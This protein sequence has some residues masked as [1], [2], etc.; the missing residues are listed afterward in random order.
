MRQ[1]QLELISYNA[2]SSF[3]LMRRRATN[4]RDDHQLHF[5]PQYELTWIINSA[6]LRY[7]GDS[8]EY[9][10]PND[11][12]LC[13]PDLPHCWQNNTVS[14][15]QHGES[16]ENAQTDAA[17]W[18]TIQFDTS[19]LPAGM[20]DMAE[21]Q[22]IAGMLRQSAYGL[23]FTGVPAE[24]FSQLNGLEAES[25]LA[26]YTRLL[27]LLASLSGLKTRTLVT[28][29]FFHY[30]TVS[31]ASVNTLNNVHQ[32]IK[33]HFASALSQSEVAALSGMTPTAF[34]RFYKSATG[35]TFSAMVKLIR[36]NE[37][38]KMLAGSS[39]PVT[40]IALNCGYQ[41]TSHFI[42]QFKDIKGMTPAA[43][44]A[45]LQSN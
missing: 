42:S 30:N 12:V 40:T 11:L 18:F 10:Q 20:E 14:H 28:A 2:G 43:Y 17:E 3:Q 38:C 36:I 41:H 13:G 24:I 27:T 26:R 21:F 45:H 44:R 33:T 16:A 35:R 15:A 9:Y 29:D 5:H 37:A 31:Q 8:V 4:F 25:G 6:G 1:P 22:D 32:H 34:S 19:L 7:V 39:L 23:Q